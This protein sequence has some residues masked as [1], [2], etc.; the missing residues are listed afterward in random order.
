MLH[1]LTIDDD[2]LMAK[3]GAWYVPRR[4]PNYL[5][6]NALIALGNTGDPSDQR[7]HDT[8]QRYLTHDTAML[9]AHAVWACNQLGLSQY[10]QLVENDADPEVQAELAAI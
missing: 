4:D 2:A 5:R 7:V 3:H 1:I 9:R 8:L 6:R 10:L